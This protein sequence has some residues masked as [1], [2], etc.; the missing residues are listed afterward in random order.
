V[1]RSP[2][3]RHAADQS[4]QRQTKARSRKR[5]TTARYVWLVVLAVVAPLVTV[6]FGS[7]VHGTQTFR[8]DSNG[9]SAPL[10]GASVRTG[11]L[12]QETSEFGRMSI[13]RVYYPGLPSPRA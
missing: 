7:A 11:N 6:A 8:F 5:I 2:K 4:R 10:F 9:T 13:I 12:A 3:G 1:Q